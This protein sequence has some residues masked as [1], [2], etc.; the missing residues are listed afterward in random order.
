M[1]TAGSVGIGLA[2]RGDDRRNRDDDPARSAPPRAPTAGSVAPPDDDPLSPAATELADPPP[3]PRT[4]VAEPDASSPAQTGGPPPSEP[5]VADEPPP[6]CADLKAWAG[7]WQVGSRVL[8]TEYAYQLDTHVD[9]A[10]TL[11]VEPRCAI[12][13]DVLKYPP[14]TEGQP[15][16]EPVAS[17][18]RSEAIL[19]PPR[20]WR[21][22]LRLGF[23]GDTRTYDVAEH[24]QTELLLDRD[25]DG[26]ARLRGAFR[27]ANAKGYVL[28]SGILQGDRHLAPSPRSID[29]ED[30]PCPARCRV[31][32]G[33]ERS[34]QGCRERGCTPWLG[35][36]HDICGPPSFDFLPPLRARATRSTVRAGDSPLARGLARGDRARQLATCADHARALAGRWAVWRIPKGPQATATRISV[37]L[38]TEGCALSGTARIDPP[39]G[40][41]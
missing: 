26:T 15:R 5:A 18:A 34:E 6:S 13:V 39:T 8:W 12:S 9:Y 32:C 41:G 22:P 3:S 2:S 21:I 36:P 17:T 25:P 27:K 37:E 24:Y 1:L 7:T 30:L 29:T 10:L 23:E 33:G 20:Q 11:T 35:D 40:A 31:Q 16:G 19:D 38:S 28:R 4:A 14:R